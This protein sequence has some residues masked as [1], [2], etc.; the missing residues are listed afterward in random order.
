MSVAHKIIVQHPLDISM[1]KQRIAEIDNAQLTERDE[2]TMYCWVDGKSARGVEVA[3]EEGFI[4]VRNTVLSNEFD[5]QLT[6]TIV[7]S[8][9]DFT[10]GKVVDEDGKSVFGQ[11]L[12]PAKKINKLEKN[13]SSLLKAVLKG[14]KQIAILGPVREVHFGKRLYDEF[15][16]FEGEELKT[17]IFDIVMNVQ[18]G[19]PFIASGSVMQVAN[20]DG[21][22]LLKLLT[23]EAGTIV[24]KY[25]FIMLNTGYENPI[26]ITNDIL[27]TMLPPGWVLADEYTIVAPQVAPVVWGQL[28]EKAAAFDQFDS[29]VSR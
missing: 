29:F 10:R 19:L 21:K 14:G 16:R 17:R 8:I 4:E 18:Y 27:N 12:Y 25:D 20:E 5:Y 15:Y 24:G 13:D 2:G 28:L 6:N 1:F 3:F 23:N 9:I 11:E 7:S 22:K 26:M